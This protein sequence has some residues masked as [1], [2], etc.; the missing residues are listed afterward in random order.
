[1]RER[2]RRFAVVGLVATTIDIGLAVI[3]LGAGW[4]PWAADAVALGLAATVARLLHRSL[5]LRDDPYARWLRLR[6]V[7]VT[8][9]V[10]ARLVALG[11]PHGARP[12][13]GVPLAGAIGPVTRVAAAG[14]HGDD[15][16]ARGDGRDRFRFFVHRRL[17][18][19]RFF[20]RDV[21]V[22]RLPFGLLLPAPL[23]RLLFVFLFR[24]VLVAR[25]RRPRP[26]PPPPGVG[27]PPSGLPPISTRASPPPQ[28]A[29]PPLTGN[30]LRHYRLRLTL[31]NLRHVAVVDEHHRHCCKASLQPQDFR[32]NFAPLPPIN[33]HVQR[34]Q[35]V[36][37]TQFDAR[38]L[39]LPR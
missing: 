14:G 1:M 36:S 23:C 18:V 29:A 37:P 31:P 34:H 30:T 19:C 38:P 11:L 7:F 28:F 13:L 6:R 24:V 4:D 12:L 8:V 35:P 9:V 2:L 15:G 3:L 26:L 21:A 22:A 25:L 10:L 27:L 33:E 32:R 5:T 16:R 39:E 17:F 20:F